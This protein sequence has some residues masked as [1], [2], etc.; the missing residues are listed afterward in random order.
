MS[1]KILWGQVV[2]YCHSVTV[3]NKG[4]LQRGVGYGE[5]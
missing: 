5:R 2:K 1:T 3:K 4:V